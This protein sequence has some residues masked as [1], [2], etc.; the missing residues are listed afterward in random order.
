MQARLHAAVVVLWLSIPLS[1]QAG[2]YRCVDA[3]G[4]IHYAQSKLPGVTCT[5]QAPAAPPPTGDSS[6]GSLAEYVEELD[7]SRAEA[8]QQ[9]QKAREQKEA[10][11]ARCSQARKHLAYLETSGGSLFTIDEKGERTYLS[12][13]EFDQR[14]SEARQRVAGECR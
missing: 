3:G 14:L 12:A 11:Q 4:Q 1:A 2:I 5:A 10:Q 7:K 8:D 9:K 6:A 13:K